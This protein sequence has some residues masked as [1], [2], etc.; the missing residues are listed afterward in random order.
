M[1]LAE[2]SKQIIN[3]GGVEEYSILDSCNILKDIVG[4]SDITHLE[5]RHEV[6]H[7]IPTW[8]KSEK[9]LGFKHKISLKEGLQ[10][11]WDWAKDQPNRERFI[12]SEYEIEKGIYSF[13]KNNK[14]HDIK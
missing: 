5:K 10:T 4:F 9:I 12:W 1:I 13:W 8:E 14:T 3:L 11:M 2:A 7:S 6:K